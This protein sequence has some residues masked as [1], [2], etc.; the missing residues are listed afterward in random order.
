LLP[1]EMVFARPLLFV[2]KSKIVGYK[3]PCSGQKVSR[4]DLASKVI[5]AAL[6]WLMEERALTIRYVDRKEKGFLRSRRIRGHEIVRKGEVQANGLEKDLQEL[7]NGEVMLKDLISA[8][9]GGESDFPHSRVLAKVERSLEAKGLGKYEGRIFKSFKLDCDKLEVPDY[10]FAELH[11]SLE[12]M[13]RRF[14]ELEREIKDVL[15]SLVE[16][17]DD[18]D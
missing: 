5:M 6:Q 15:K 2:K 3:D 14:P 9:V 4:E 7:S 8:L 13:S 16:T 11:S 10:K 18:W 1:S 12:D 17:D